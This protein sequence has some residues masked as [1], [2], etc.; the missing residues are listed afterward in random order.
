MS[1]I[2]KTFSFTSGLEGWSAENAGTASNFSVDWQMFNYSMQCSFSN[3]NSGSGNAIWTGTWE[4]LGVP[5]FS[6]INSVSLISYYVSVPTLS[7]TGGI[8]GTFEYDSQSL[9]DYVYHEMGPES[10][11]NEVLGLLIAKAPPGGS[12]A[13]NSLISFRLKT[14]IYG[15]GSGFNVFQY[16]TIKIQI[17]YTEGEEEV[18]YISGNESYPNILNIGG[19]N[20]FG[21]GILEPPEYISDSTLILGGFKL[22]NDNHVDPPSYEGSGQLVLGGVGIESDSHVLIPGEADSN[23]SLYIFSEGFESNPL[24]MNLFINGNIPGLMFDYTGYSIFNR[25]TMSPSLYIK[26]EVAS[27]YTKSFDSK[28]LFIEGCILETNSSMNLY[29]EQRFGGTAST[30]YI[31]GSYVDLLNNSIQLFCNSHEAKYGSIPMFLYTGKT[32]QAS[33]P[34]YI[35]GPRIEESYSS[36]YTQGP[37]IKDGLFNMTIGG[38]NNEISN[39][40]SLVIYG[41]SGDGGVYEGLLGDNILLNDYRLINSLSYGS[42]GNQNLINLASQPLNLYIEVDSKGII[43]NAIN[44]HI[45]SKPMSIGY[46]TLFIQNENLASYNQADLWIRGL[47]KNPGYRPSEDN[48]NLFV[49]GFGSGD[50]IS[51]V[52]NDNFIDLII[53]GN[54]AYI[55]KYN[56]Y[57]PLYINSPNS[58]KVDDDATLYIGGETNP[59]TTNT[60]PLFVYKPILVKNTTLY[61]HGF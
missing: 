46:T 48:M 42:G 26:G 12:T 1:I 60:I 5:E 7:A 55:V 8:S 16:K 61:I 35:D 52:F 50:L 57:A 15:S 58:I 51:P 56:R 38:R 53:N 23:T 36:L 6:T 21:T 29:I 40:T 45:G 37:F 14:A 22:S 49:N 3:N 59:I 4:D 2:T 31:E 19:M 17:D 10:E 11:F 32:E 25:P 44:L 13:S 18:V 34:L 24:G 9:S 30:L 54:I 20:L 28:D 41:W 47:G 33:I 43:H 39:Q 27:P